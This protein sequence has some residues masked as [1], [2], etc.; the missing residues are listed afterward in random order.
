VQ[1]SLF[2][3]VN[4]PRGTV[5][6]WRIDTPGFEM[7]GKTGTSQVRRISLQ[8]RRDGIKKSHER[9][10]SHRDHALYIGYTLAQ[11]GRPPF[12][13]AVVVDHGGWGGPAAAPLGRD[14]LRHVQQLSGPVLT[15]RAQ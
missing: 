15:E 8:E 13:V 11:G 14:I 5:Y 2:D 3:V 7:A 12:A 4:T 10:W 6:R 9:P 1:K